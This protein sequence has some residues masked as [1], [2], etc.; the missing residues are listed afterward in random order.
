MPTVGTGTG[1]DTPSPGC[2]GRGKSSGLAVS[3]TGDEI[4]KV[5]AGVCSS[6]G[7]AGGAEGLS[8]DAVGAVSKIRLSFF[9]ES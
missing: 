6:G 2:T 7:G 3:R 5:P 1:D 9:F 8:S 4:S